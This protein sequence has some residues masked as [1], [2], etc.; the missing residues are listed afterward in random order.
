MQV[1]KG[2]KRSR[3]RN[4]L[5]TKTGKAL[6][7]NRTISERRKDRKSDRAARK[8]LYLR[9]LPKNKFLRVV[10]RLHPK[11]QFEYWF[12]RD[13]LI[14]FLKIFGIGV[15]LGFFLIIGLFAYF[16]KDLPQLNNITGSNVGGSVTYYDS[17]GKNVL[18][19]D[20]SAVKRIPVPSSQINN[21]MKEATIAIE[22]KNF[23]H[24]GAFSITGTLRAAVNDLTGGSLQGGSTLTQQL[25]KLNENWTDNRT[26]VRKV[27]ELILAVEVA[28]EYSK[29]DILTGYLNLAPYGGVDYGVEAAAED[30]FQTSAANLT[31]AQASMLAA[32]PQ[33][34]TYYSPYSDSQYNPAVTGNYFSATGLIGR[35]HYVLQQMVSL[36][37]ISQAQADA[38]AAVDILAQVHPQQGLYQNIKAP[39]FVLAAK[40]QLISQFGSAFYLKGGLKVI[41]TLNM[42][43]QTHAEQ[44]VASNYN[45]IQRMTAGRADEEATVTEDVKTGWIVDMVGGVNF[46]NPTDGQIN[47]A[48]SVLIPPGSSF[49][50]YDYSTLINN[51]NNVGAGSVLYDQ[52]GPLP[53]YPCTNKALPS[54][55]GNCLEDYDF[56]SPGPLTIRYAL[57]GSR[58]IPAVKAM[59]EAVP[60]NNSNGHVNSINKVIS[61]ASAMMDNTSAQALHQNSYN[62]YK[63]GTDMSTATYTDTTQCYAASAIG[64]GGFL[65]LDDHVNGLSTIARMG[66]AIP[67]TFIDKITDSSNKVLYQWTQPKPTQVLN[68]DTAYIMNNMLS[69]PNASYLPGSCSATNC[70]PLSS[71]G[72]KFQH[73]NG[74][75]FAIKTGTTNNGYDGLMVSW[76]TQYATVSWVGNHT[77]NVNLCLSSE[78]TM[79]YLTEPL[80]RGMMEFAHQGL[81]PV[82]WT[83][84]SDIKTLPAFV[85]TKHVHY[86]DVEPSPANELFPSWYVGNAK[87]SISSVKI[88]KVSG[89][90]A[91]TCTPADA[92]QQQSNTDTA[93][94]NIDIFVNNGTP[95][96]ATSGSGSTSSSTP[97]K[98]DNVHNCNDSPPT[99]KL[100]AVDLVGPNKNICDSSCNFTATV[101]Q[102]T[103]LLT[104]PTNYPQFPGNVSMTV[105]GSVIQISS[106]GSTPG[107]SV[108]I[109]QPDIQTIPINFTPATNGSGNLVSTV[110]DS[111]L[112]QSNSTPLSITFAAT[113]TIVSITNSTTITWSGGIGPFTITDVSKG[114]TT[115]CDT[116]SA[117]NPN[118][119][120]CTSKIPV[121]SGDQ[122]NISDAYVQGPSF[123]AP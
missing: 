49:K 87:S 8:A 75:D 67:R 117:S 16:R 110:T 119:T 6:S 102:G 74:W 84:P 122:L 121:L 89:L 80:T 76:S 2:K 104:D 58:N 120:S 47:Y 52:V 82:N 115:L 9:T 24:E 27:K 105:N 64:D 91:T 81:K 90:V 100:T 96:I 62:C 56:L 85:V 73:D 17:T 114:N 88:D 41:T 118:E 7:I 97:T 98:T 54:N 4:N 46:N 71:F 10:Y 69:D 77:R 18:W 70:T 83:Q 101:Q 50:P 44:L 3:R 23:Y 32:I 15:V 59:L 111:V 57:G 43:L 94:W 72:Y 65:Y 12:S 55:G 25:V 78:C 26:I 95:N 92:I 53:G 39:Y 30:Y 48:A 103:H 36:H 66:Q 29:N 40:Q 19:Q 112:E 33:A 116:S 99:I 68:Q 20:Y 108:A 61:T 45:S 60:N 107:S 31:L 28:R 21:Y 34:P 86:G 113:P 37:Y 38:A 1:P 93:S 5:K 42:S 106:N 13:G 51:N 79:E 123:T 63:Q 11:H 22:D 35:Q 109:T 14:M